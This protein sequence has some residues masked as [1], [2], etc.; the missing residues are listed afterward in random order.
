MQEL[1]LQQ[2]DWDDPVPEK[3]TFQW[4]KY[5]KELSSLE[6][7]EIPR[8]IKV[9]SVSSEI[10]LHGFSDASERA[11]AAVVYIRVILNEAVHVQLLTAKSKIA[12]IKRISLPK[13]ELC[14]AVLLAKL[15][16]SVKQ[17]MNFQRVETFAW[18]DSM[19]TLSWIRANPSKWKPFVANRVTEIQSLSSTISW[20]HI[21]TKNNPADMASRGLYPSEIENLAMWWQGP[22]MLK[23]FTLNIITKTINIDT[24]LEMRRVKTITLTTFTAQF[25]QIIE[26][27]S[28]LQKLQRVIAYCQ[29]AAHNFK[30]ANQRKTN[31][32]TVAELEAALQFVIKITQTEEF[33]EEISSLTKHSM[34]TNRS[35]LLTLHPFIDKDNILRVG[36]RLQNANIDYDRQ[37]PIILPRNH[38]LTNLII[39]DAHVKTQHGGQTITT[40]FIQTKFWIIGAKN[41]IKRILKKCITCFKVNATR[42][43]QLM[44]NLPAPRV[45]IARPFFNTG[46]D[47]AGPLEIKAWKGRCNRYH[48]GYI[49]IF[50][51]L[52]TKAIHIELV[53]DLSTAA[54]IAAYHRFSSR[55]GI[56]R[57]IYSDCGTNFVG[58]DNKLKHE[59]KT[60]S[61]QW[62]SEISEALSSL[63]T[64][65]HFNPPAS[66]HFGGLWEAGVK[67]I[68][69]HLKRVT[70]LAK[71]TFEEYATLLSQ[72]EACL[73]SRPLCP[74][75][76][77]PGDFS[78][79]TPGHFLIMSALNTPPERDLEDRKPTTLDRWQYIQQLYQ[80]F[81]DKWSSEYLSRLQQRPKWN[82]Q[83]AN[84]QEGD[85]VLL[86]DGRLPPTHWQ[87]ARVTATHPGKD[88]LTRVVTVSTN[89]ST[90]QRPI[91]KVCLLPIKD[92]C[93]HPTEEFL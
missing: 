49:A 43:R 35:K 37:H 34:V 42:S 84:I 20:H 17:A 78:T 7:I 39:P 54:F 71:L 52:C 76:S 81:W 13:L 14:A 22:P 70:G 61:K 82:T 85:L 25:K 32:I 87:L 58:A 31:P 57:N 86:R 27:Y 23:T 12:P 47:Y 9:T 53:S 50:I 45:Q 5:R 3:L 2:L 89:K 66:P 83:H 6:R 64:Q 26:K 73:N 92:N 79:L 24:D 68:K 4:L 51:C 33:N 29:R 48:K 11:Y 28:T 30:N 88:K 74:R 44:G 63:G 62:S 60:I 21:G 75:S 16:D 1:W 10:Q 67:S 55:R 90:F 91:H 65:W 80:S 59:F 41:N 46:V 56:C 8:W 69:Y 36:G 93:H 18:T 15:L 19:I 72:I 77:E 40:E 38:H